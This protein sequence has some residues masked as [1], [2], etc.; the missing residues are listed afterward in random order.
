MGIELKKQG[1][2]DFLILEK[3]TGVG[4]T[5]RDNTYPGCACDVPSH[6]YSFSF[7]PKS[8]WSNLFSYQPEILSYLEQVAQKYRLAEHIKFGTTFTG[9]RWNDAECRWHVATAD[10]REFIGQFLVSGIGALHVPNIPELPG[11]ETF[12]GPTFHSARWDHLVD[13]TGMNVA[14]IGTGASAVQ[15]VPEIIDKV[16]ALQVYQRTP[17]WVLPRSNVEFSARAKRALALVPGLRRLLRNGLYWSAEAGAY[18]MTRRP[19]MLRIVER[20]AR[21][22]LEREIT[23]PELRRKLTPTYRA[24]CKRLLGSD[25][26]Y[27][28]LNKPKTE[29]VTA[30]I[31][32]VTANGIVTSDGVERPVD[33]IIYGTGFHIFDVFTRLDFHGRYGVDIA[34]RWRNEGVQAYLGT[35]IADA[36]NAFF[37]LGPNT[38]LGHTSVVFM[39]EAQ[40]RYVSQAI[41]LA[42]REG[43]QA[44][45]PRRSAQAAFNRELQRKLRRS[46]WNTGGC[47]SWYLDAH[48]ENR[49]LWS[50]FT[51][52]Y[53]ARARKIDA[54]DFEFLT[55][56][57]PP[58]RRTAQSAPAT[59]DLV[60]D[61]L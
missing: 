5:W 39:I 6:L 2:E 3:G 35:A 12:T 36:P 47:A 28:A 57:R 21:R 41:R 26:Y 48:G 9:A 44:I 59:R 56:P 42:E 61:Q 37:L 43:A 8:S 14:V 11:I 24:G 4:G 1:I 20:I 46:V 17:P 52:E 18:A 40:I 49:T 22:H 27:A 31:Q 34:D 51:W 50:G 16:A 58:I 60:S 45:V 32:A 53:W 29:V 33:A 19:D 10:G 30:A 13:L 23:D 54:S 25:T 55:V 38:G 15:F 7:E